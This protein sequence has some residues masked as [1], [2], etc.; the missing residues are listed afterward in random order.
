MGY[1]SDVENHIARNLTITRLLEGEFI[2]GYETIP[3]EVIGGAFEPLVDQPGRSIQGWFDPNGEPRPQIDVIRKWVEKHSGSTQSPQT[4]SSYI[5]HYLLLPSYEWGISD[6]HLD[7]IRPFIKKYQPTV[8]FSLDEAK[9]AKRVT[10]IGG[11]QA[12]SEASLNQLRAAGIL[13]KRIDENGTDIAS[14]I[15][16]L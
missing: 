6:Y 9:N 15:T 4:T 5:R 13:V 14:L 3:S 7:I 11:E 1:S 2:E 10:V 12:F 8:G 16:T